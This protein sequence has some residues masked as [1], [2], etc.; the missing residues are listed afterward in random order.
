MIT[1]AP[2]PTSNFYLL[3]KAI[4]EDKRLSWAARGMLVFLLGKP[5]NW[6]VSPAA[7]VNETASASRCMGR[8]G[9]YAVLKELKDVGYLRTVGNRT[10]GGTFAGADYMVSE[11]PCAEYPDSVVSPH[12]DLPYP[13]QP[14]PA[15]PPQVSTDLKQGLNKKKGL[16]EER[17]SAPPLDIPDS[18]LADYLILRKAKKAGPLTPTTIAGLQRE[19]DKAGLTLTQ[20]VTACCEFGWQGFNAGWYDSRTA[21]RTALTAI[22]RAPA[23]SFAERDS[24]NRRREW[25]AM[26]NRQ[27][28]DNDRPSTEPFVIDV[29]AN[30]QRR[31]S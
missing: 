8:D 21:G 14:Y 22:S 31:I 15:N 27:W 6:T 25:E 4:S 7:L 18:L 12:T 2:R 10:D 17:A 28:P 3:D 13:V 16:K 30:E 19:A 26:T 1:R 9:V 11:S 24:A 29:Q 20:A 23:E 5:D